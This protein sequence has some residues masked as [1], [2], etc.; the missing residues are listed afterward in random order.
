MID[1][2]RLAA[3]MDDQGLEGKGEPLE[4][5]F[6]SGGSQNEIYELRRG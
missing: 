5:A 6:V 1:F 3:W 4:H 2:D